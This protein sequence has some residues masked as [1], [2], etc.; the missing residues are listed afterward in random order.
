MLIQVIEG[1]LYEKNNYVQINIVPQNRA[2]IKT[3]HFK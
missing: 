3:Q 1:D 2:K